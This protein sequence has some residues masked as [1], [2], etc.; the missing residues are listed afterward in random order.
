MILPEESKK[1]ED[2]WTLSYSGTI[3]RT[4]MSI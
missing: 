1:K 3:L 4:D 2:F